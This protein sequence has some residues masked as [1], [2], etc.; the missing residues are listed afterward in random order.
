MANIM[1]KFIDDPIKPQADY[2]QKVDF[3]PLARSNMFCHSIVQWW[4][5]TGGSSVSNK[6]SARPW[7][8]MKSLENLRTLTL[9]SLK[10][11]EK[12]PDLQKSLPVIG[13]IKVT[14]TGVILRQNCV[15][16]SDAA[17][18]NFFKNLFYH[19]HC[20]YAMNIGVAEIRGALYSFI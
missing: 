4:R 5:N 9:N 1:P 20:Q 13:Q 10:N 18:D 12:L 17:L 16:F 7:K 15:R 19:K 14:S 8:F 6:F 3:R 2:S 11:S